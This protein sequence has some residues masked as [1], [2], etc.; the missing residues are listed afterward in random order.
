MRGKRGFVLSMDL[1]LSL[2]IIFLIL[3]MLFESEEPE[4][5]NYFIASD[6]LAIIQRYYGVSMDT[7]AMD[8]RI[9]KTLP[10]SL[11]NFTLERYGPTDWSQP[12]EIAY[13]ERGNPKGDTAE[14]VTLI[15]DGDS[16]IGFIISKLEV[17]D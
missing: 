3:A 8:I 10:F 5:V 9:N 13:V 17:Q 12:E 14:R 7:N 15:F 4:K 1:M 6:A 16:V 2:I 11:V